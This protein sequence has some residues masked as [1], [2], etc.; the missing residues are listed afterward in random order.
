MTTVA[1]AATVDQDALHAALLQKLWLLTEPILINSDRFAILR[2]HSRM[3][4]ASDDYF[5]SRIKSAWFEE[6]SVKTVNDLQLSL[7][8]KLQPR[9][10][11]RI[12]GQLQL[13]STRR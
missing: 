5:A 3:P 4:E 2:M 11:G 9:R 8:E 6:F 12:C 10:Q 7:Q 1:V 13:R